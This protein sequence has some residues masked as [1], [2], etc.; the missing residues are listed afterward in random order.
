MTFGNRGISNNSFLFSK[1]V[2]SVRSQ[3]SA[4]SKAKF[5]L[6]LLRSRDVIT[7]AHFLI[8]VLTVIS[9]MS[10]ALQ[11]RGTCVYEFHKQLE[12]TSTYLQ[13]LET[14]FFWNDVMVQCTEC[15]QM[16]LIIV[17]IKPNNPSLLLYQ[18]YM[19]LCIT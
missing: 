1:Q 10:M 11:K 17:S 7:F 13:K 3:S 12:L 2:A 9:S 8:D 16:Y 6:K 19:Q 18:V 15:R 5:F 14:R 4:Q